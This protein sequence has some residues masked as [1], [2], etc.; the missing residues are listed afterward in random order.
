VISVIT[1]LHGPGN[2]YIEATYET[3]MQQTFAEWEWVVLEN[4]HGMLPKYIARDHR[5][6]LLRSESSKIG[7]LKSLASRAA[8]F[9]YILELDADDLLADDALEV[10]V[11]TFERERADFVYS[12]CAYFKSGSFE[13]PVPFD[14]YFGWS[15]YEVEF[16][17]HT[18]K[19]MRTP[20]VNAQNLRYIYYCPD[21]F[22]A[23]RKSKYLDVGG[24]DSTMSV[25]DDHDLM[26][27]MFL[28]DAKFVHVPRALYFYRVHEQQTTKTQNRD[29]QQATNAVYNRYI[30]KL[31]EK[32]A[33]PDKYDL[34]GGINSVPGYIPVDKVLPPTTHNARFRVKCD[35]DEKWPFSDNSVGLLR[36]N[37]CV[38]HLRNQIHTMNE[39]YRVLK[40]GGFFMIDVP[41]TNGK[42]AF[43]DPTHVSFWN[44][45]SFRYYTNPQFARFVHEFQ[46][47]F[48]TLR[49]IEWFPSAW[50]E[51][52]NVPYVQAHL[53]ALKP[54]YEPMGE[55]WRG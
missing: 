44:D 10:A 41:S 30:W 2:P 43:C 21:H 31:A 27:R 15:H 25:A 22:R 38:E 55:A 29:I 16:R 4:N 36:A 28:A 40:P 14:A 33:G 9:E 49:V 47:R 42:G 6:T 23:W 32:F 3:L 39:A 8:K 50:H 46:G 18:L 13:A 26:V 1:P 53:V 7:A 5:V 54:G 34:C 20:P 24:H 12:D 48:Q 37:D 19:A 51:Q 17:G 11:S 52:N 45:L 35:L